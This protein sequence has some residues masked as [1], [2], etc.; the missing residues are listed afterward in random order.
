MDRLNAL[1]TL[2]EHLGRDPEVARAIQKAHRE[3]INRK[4]HFRRTKAGALKWVEP[5]QVLAHIAEHGPEPNPPKDANQSAWM[6]RQAMAE[7]LNGSNVVHA[8]HKKGLGWVD[9]EQGTTGDG[10]PEYKHGWG[11]THIKTKRDWQH[12]QKHSRPNG[13]KTLMMLP[14]VIAKGRITESYD[15]GM[16]IVHNGVKVILARAERPKGEPGHAWLVSGYEA[17]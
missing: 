4:G 7:A 15:N 8:M 10:P 16:V 13:E 11:I 17:D 9:F 3:A 6:G 2:A 1:F 5:H 14:E 12:E